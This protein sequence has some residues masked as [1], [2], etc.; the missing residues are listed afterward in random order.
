MV[1]AAYGDYL[2]TL[3]KYDEA[4]IAYQMADD[5]EKAIS[6]YSQALN[7][8]MALGLARKCGMEEA[9]IQELCEGMSSK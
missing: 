5:T 4:A 3:R 2:T 6:S 9:R 8:K 7:W 1:S